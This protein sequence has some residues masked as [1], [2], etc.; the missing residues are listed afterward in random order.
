GAPARDVAEEKLLELWHT[1]DTLEVRESL[2]V[3]LRRLGVTPP[4][5]PEHRRNHHARLEREWAD[6]SPQSPARV[7]AVRT[8]RHKRQLE[9]YSTLNN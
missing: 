5:S 4:A 7:C 8:E 1:N 3:A 9:K 6:I 2:F